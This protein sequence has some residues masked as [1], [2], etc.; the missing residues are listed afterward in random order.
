MVDG[1]WSSDVRRLVMPR[2][3]THDLTIDYRPPTIDRLTCNRQQHIV[4][5]MGP[6]SNTEAPNEIKGTQQYAGDSAEGKGSQ[7]EVVAQRTDIVKCRE[8][9]RSQKCREDSR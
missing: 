7:L 3:Q 8:D 9:H 1:R 5:G 6:G 4:Q 2:L